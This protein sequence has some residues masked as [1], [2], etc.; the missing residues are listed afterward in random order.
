MLAALWKADLDNHNG[1]PDSDG[2]WGRFLWYDLGDWRYHYRSSTTELA[3]VLGNL[4]RAIDA[5]AAQLPPRNEETN[6]QPIVALADDALTTWS[7]WVDRLTE[8]QAA[9][10]DASDIQYLAK[11]RGQTLR[12]AL[13]L[14]AIR[15]ASAG[16]TLATPIPLSTLRDAIALVALFAS[17]RQ[18]LLAP[19]RSSV[20]GAI[21]RLLDRGKAWR[22]QHGSQPVPQR[23]IRNWS[24]PARL[25]PSLEVR[26][27]LLE[28]VATTPGCGTVR[29]SGK[30]VEWIPP[31]D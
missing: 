9:A 20:A 22:Q 16:L 17:E 30:T 1:C 27:W 13:V 10:T 11:Q 8:L 14:H 25:C 4:Y 28:V 19:V 29:R 2:L 3:P 21:Q 6:R 7:A 5:Q 18:K 31:G 15:Q 12:L 24:L 26:R 23:I